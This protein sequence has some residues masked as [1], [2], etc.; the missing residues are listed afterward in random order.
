MITD[1]ILPKKPPTSTQEAIATARLLLQIAGVT[2]ATVSLEKPSTIE[3]G[4]A[5]AELKVHAPVAA[6][7]EALH[8]ALASMAAEQGVKL[9]RSHLALSQTDP[10]R[11]HLRV[12]VEVKV[13]GGIMEMSVQG[14]LTPENGTHLR[15]SG[16]KMEGGG[17]MF[18]G[19]ATSM[20]R[21][22]IA[23]LE[24]APLDLQKLAGVPLELTQL[25]Y[26]GE[27]LTLTVSFTDAP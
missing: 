15:F 20:I 3:G 8:K 24:A 2:G 16:M 19:I 18:G 17:G 5:G 6:L 14:D 10:Q 26:T 22:R 25:A 9:T 4:L 11:L 27:A 23:A 21:P 7:E 1:P 12:G 13:F